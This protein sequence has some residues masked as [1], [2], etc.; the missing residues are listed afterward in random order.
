MSNHAA[1]LV[2]ELKY[3]S[4]GPEDKDSYRTP[5]ALFY[6]MSRAMPTHCFSYD[7]AASDANALCPSY[8]TREDD[9]LSKHWDF[10][11]RPGD[12]LFNNPPYSKP[13]PWV[14][15]AAR[16]KLVNVAMVLN[17]D[18]STEWYLTAHDAGAEFR[19][20]IG[21]RVHY[22]GADDKP[23]R[24]TMKCQVIINFFTD[25]IPGQP[26]YKPVAYKDI[27]L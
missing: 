11:A 24:E 12:S 2:K 18:C 5:P 26:T 17:L 25:R 8:L 23:M 1:K 3:S 10:L 7:L 15:A 21:G 4:V 16:C 20:I 6:Y 19:P 13:L 14:Q 9:A 22:H 27:F